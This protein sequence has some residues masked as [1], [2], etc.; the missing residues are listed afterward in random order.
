MFHRHFSRAY[1]ASALGNAAWKCRSCVLCG[2]A[3]ELNAAEV[4]NIEDLVIGNRAAWST[5]L[6]MDKIASKAAVGNN[7]IVSPTQAPPDDQ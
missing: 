3:K 4:S 1:A 7:V 2:S 6:P 5:A